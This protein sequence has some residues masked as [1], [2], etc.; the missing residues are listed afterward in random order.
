MKWLAERRHGVEQC[1]DA[2]CTEDA[3]CTADD[4]GNAPFCLSKGFPA[5]HDKF[6]A[7]K[8]DAHNNQSGADNGR[9][10]ADVIDCGL[11]L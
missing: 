4:H 7:A 5:A 9:D 3:D 1:L 8:D 2:L 10:C 6:H 11:E